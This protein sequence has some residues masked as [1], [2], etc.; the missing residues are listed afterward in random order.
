MV[1]HQQQ[2]KTTSS[3]SPQR[4]GLP[5]PT[6][7]VYPTEMAALTNSG[8]LDDV[9]CP[10][11]TTSKITGTQAQLH[12][13][14]TGDVTGHAG[15]STAQQAKVSAQAM[16]RAQ[17]FVGKSQQ[18][19]HKL[20]IHAKHS[21]WLMRMIARVIST[22]SPR[23][24]LHKAR[25]ENTAEAAVHNARWLKHY[26]WDLPR[27]LIRQKGTIMEP[28]SEFRDWE[29]LEPL[30]VAH[31]HWPKMKEI[32]S[33]G[34]N[35]PLDPI[36]EEERQADLEHMILRGNHKSAQVPVEN[37]ATLL[38]NYEKEVENGWMLPIPSR[39]LSKLKGAAVIPVG[40]HT[41]YTINEC[42]ERKVKRR[43]THDASFAPPSNKS[44]NERMQRDLLTECFYGYCLLRILHAIHAMRISHPLICIL[45]IKI[46]LDAAYRRLHVTAKMALLTITI[47]KKIAYILLRLPFG[48]ANGPNDYSLISEPLF[49]LT[50]EI[51]RDPSYD[52]SLL[53]SPIQE[54]LQ[55]KDISYTSS[56]PFGTARPLFV[57]V[58]FH[59]AT[60]DG[61]IDDIITVV[62]DTAD[63]L[64]RAINAAPL[65][66]HTLFRPVDCRDPLP[67]AE[68]VSERKL[69]GEGTPAEVKNVLGW[70]VDTRLFRI[71]LPTEKSIDW[72][73][74]IEHMLLEETVSTQSLEKTIGR[75]NHA[76]HIIP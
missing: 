63:W 12:E 47:I 73:M 42:G 59:F 74:K 52:P 30:W 29:T 15:I 68:S 70:K 10:T 4:Q 19:T 41:Q 45:L 22:P 40:V 66:I 33:K 23:M 11:G 3:M 60:A 71:F 24:K 61:Y 18:N 49:D 76:G 37:A 58:P 20:D 8:Q 21:S 67:R 34:V 44:V 65:A 7:M 1:R 54:Q 36:T 26:Q 6:P 48:V 62:L 17:K 16:K 53:H 55:D 14:K 46:D 75:L 39:C 64:R 38:S 5:T 72:S 50:N 28:G 43:T 25:F 13:G 69:K 27:A 57:N 2:S 51:L 56:T 35:Y 32:I 9:T 31:R